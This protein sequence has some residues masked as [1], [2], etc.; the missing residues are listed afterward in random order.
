MSVHVTEPRSERG[1]RVWVLT[2][3]GTTIGS[4]G[5]FAI[6]DRF[7]LNRAISSLDTGVQLNTQAITEIKRGIDASTV[8]QAEMVKSLRN[9]ELALAARGIKV[10]EMK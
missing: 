5:T 1:W 6:K 10:R 4:V 2:I 9:I 8:S 3:V 7:D